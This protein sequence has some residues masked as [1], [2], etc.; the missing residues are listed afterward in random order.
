MWRGITKLAKVPTVTA[1]GMRGLHSTLAVESAITSTVVAAALGHES[2]T[3]NLQSYAQPSA[4]AN[5]RQTMVIEVL[6]LTGKAPADGAEQPSEGSKDS[7]QGG[8][9]IPKPV[10]APDPEKPKG[11]AT[12]QSPS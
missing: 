3:T 9:A 5:A 10:S 4:L 2:I 11:P 6:D 8:N 7:C 12:T 1:H